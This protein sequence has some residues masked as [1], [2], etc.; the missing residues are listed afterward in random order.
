M[1]TYHLLLSKFGNEF[2]FR[3]SLWRFDVLQECRMIENAVRDAVEADAIILATAR[4]EL[5]LAVQ[6]WIDAWAPLKRGQTAAL[7][8]LLDDGG[9]P[10]HHYLERAATTAELEFMVTESERLPP[11][12]QFPNRPAREGWGLN[13]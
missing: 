11:F 13:D 4:D 9:S 5:P 12:P 6:Q 2:D 3:I 1:D 8:A 10:A 7:I